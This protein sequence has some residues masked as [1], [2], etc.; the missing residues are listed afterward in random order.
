MTAQIEIP[1]G[2]VKNA[3]GH[4]VPEHQ[5]REQDKLRDNVARDLATQALAISESMAAF[6]TKAL[7]DIEDLISISLERYGVKLGGKKGN[8]S[9]TTYDGEFKIERALANRLSFTEEILAAKELIYACIRKWS[10]GA[11]RHL[12]ALVDRAF[13]GRNGEI[14]TND[15]LDLMRLEIDDEDWKTAMEALRDSIQV[16]GKAVYIRVYRRIGDDR[17]EQINLNLAGA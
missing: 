12:M 15:V 1:A 8:V 7:A 4:L 16:N 2:F 6:K 9:I 13:T 5:V 11:D 3:A 17:Y 14:R 10:A